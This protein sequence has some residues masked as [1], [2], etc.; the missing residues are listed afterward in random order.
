M[1]I[2]S[3]NIHRSNVLIIS[4]ISKL[5]VILMMNS[6]GMPILVLKLI[7]MK[8]LH[9]LG[10]INIEEFPNFIS[11][12]TQYLN[13]VG[14]S[15]DPNDVIYLFDIIKINEGKVALSDEGIHYLKILEI[16][17]NSTTEVS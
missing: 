4:L 1:K 2:K 13:S 12:I 15:I 5:I 9:K 16:L 3:F 14:Y 7:L 11:K 17:T 8:E 10:G 6:Q